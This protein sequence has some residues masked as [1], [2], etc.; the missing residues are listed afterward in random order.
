VASR[1]A[2]FRRL[3]GVRLFR[4]RFGFFLDCVL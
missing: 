3:D 4:I 1:L 2:T